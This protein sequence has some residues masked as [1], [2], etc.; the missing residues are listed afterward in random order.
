MRHPIIAVATLAAL[1]LPAAAR[2]QVDAVPEESVLDG[3][4]ITL[5]V[6]GIYG[7]SYEGSDDQVLSPVPLVLGSVAGI[8]I[9]PRPGGVALDF[10]PDG[11]DPRFG[12]LLGPVATYSR[13]RRSKI[14]DPV[15]RAAGKLKTAFD[16]G[17]SGGVVAYKLLSDFDSLTFTTDVRWNVNDSY[18]GMVITPAISYLTPLSRAAVVNLN[19]TAKHVDDDYAAYY[20]GVS[21]AQSA[22]SGLPRFFAEGGWASVGVNLLG[23]YD[24]DGNVLNGGFSLVGLASYSKLLDDAKDTPYTS[25]RGDDNQWLVGAGVA[26]T[27]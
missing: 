7:P 1:A 9:T 5:G 11:K 27:F 19:I 4:F 17:V 25:I 21:P 14:E 2:A 20:Y 8:D 16:V 6:G 15:V 26:Y 22:G 23:A 3:D 13:N 12:F 10:I 24:L 18:K